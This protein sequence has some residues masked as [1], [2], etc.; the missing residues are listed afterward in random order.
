MPFM[1]RSKNYPAPAAISRRNPHLS[2]RSMI[3]ALVATVNLSKTRNRVPIP[4]AFA[5][6]KLILMKSE[7]RKQ[8]LPTK[9]YSNILLN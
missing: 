1:C 9:V 3:I 2:G 8:I 7:K 5:I 4:V 6:V